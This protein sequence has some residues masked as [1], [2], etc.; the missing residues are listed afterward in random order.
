MAVSGSSPFYL[1][2]F[3]YFQNSSNILSAPYGDVSKSF[4]TPVASKS[5]AVQGFDWTKP[6]PGSTKD[7]HRIYL[8]VGE[9]MPLSEQ[10]VQDATTVLT[11][12]TFGAPAALMDNGQPRAMDPSWYVCRH[13]FVS[14]KPEV[15]KAVDGGDDQ[16]AFLPSACVK[17]L[18]DSLTSSWGTLDENSMCSAGIFDNIPERCFDSFGQARQDVIAF[19]SRTLADHDEGLLQTSQNQQLYSWRI[20]T[21]YHDPS[22][23]VAYQAAANRTYMVA[24]VWGYSKDAS[25]KKTPSV[26]L[27]CVSGGDAYVPPPPVSSTTT[28]STSKPTSTSST[29]TTS[30]QSPTSTAFF[31]DDFSSQNLDRWA[32][33]DGKF[34]ADQGQMISFNPGGKAL[35]KGDKATL[36]DLAFEANV[37]VTSTSGGN[38]GL[39][40]RV[41]VGSA[42]AGADSYKGYYAGVAGGSV[43]FGLADGN[44]WKQLSQVNAADVKAGMVQRVR[45]EAKGDS[46]SVYVGDMSKPRISVHDGTYKSGGFGV[47]AIGTL[48]FVDNVTVAML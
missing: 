21:G 48:M 10:I 29:S 23:T 4:A 27:G 32:V 38:G 41:A 37:K 40:F 31:S 6:Y 43:V 15:K 36:G 13:I 22:S 12:L 17:D 33:V 18:Q 5:A 46:I 20:G 25:N 34:S 11:S 14:T 35:V 45:V 7:V 42:A 16:C 1:D 39:I 28:T 44:G 47:R 30:S 3:D 8:S 2:Y 9:E 26:S 19:D 24:T